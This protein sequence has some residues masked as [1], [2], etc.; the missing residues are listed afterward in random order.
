MCECMCDWLSAEISWGALAM[1]CERVNVA[2]AEERW[3]EEK[4]LT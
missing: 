1:C 4:V 3:V 2:C